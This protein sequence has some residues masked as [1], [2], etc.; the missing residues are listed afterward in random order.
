MDIN[1]T[2]IIEA[3][4]KSGDMTSEYQTAKSAG[5]T[6]QIGFW[7]GL[8]GTVAQV[9]LAAIGVTAAASP[10]GIAAT[11]IV[12]I[13]GLVV[14]MVTANKYVQSRTDVKTASA[15]VARAQLENP[16]APAP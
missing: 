16:V 7:A 1:T 13:S 15:D 8:A 9:V 10:V 2:P 4:A 5:L 12:T 3:I 14:H 11:A 6:G